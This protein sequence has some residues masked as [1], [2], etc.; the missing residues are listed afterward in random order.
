M[1]SEFF[2]LAVNN[3]QVKEQLLFCF[4]TGKEVKPC[5]RACFCG[6]LWKDK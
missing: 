1:F 5:E 6:R 3:L 4:V 2:I